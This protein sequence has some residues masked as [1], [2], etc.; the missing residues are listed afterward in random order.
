MLNKIFSIFIKN[1]D[2]VENPVVRYAYGKFLNITC[3]IFNVLLFAIK[4]LAGII[5]G[6]VAIIAD[7][8]NNITDAS[9]NVVGFLGFKLANLPADEEHPYGHGRYEYVASLVVAFI[10]MFIG[11]ELFRGSLDKILNPTNI[12]FE[13]VTVLILV[14][15]ILIKLFMSVLSGFAG[16]KIKSDTLI[17]VSTDSRNDVMST[18]AVLV[19]LI[20]FKIFNINIDGYVGIIVS[21]V[22]LISGIK[23][24]AETVGT[25]LGKAPDKEFVDKLRNKIMSYESVLGTHDLMVHDYGPGRRFASVHIEMPAEEDPIKS[26]EIIDTIEMDIY[27]EM[28]LHISIHY[29]PISTKDE[30]LNEMK[31]YIALG[32]K[33]IS[34]HATIHDLRIVRGIERNIAV[35]DLLLPYSVKISE[36]QIKEETAKLVK[37]KYSS[38]DINIKIDRDFASGK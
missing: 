26:H 38:F 19:S 23:I 8:I 16:K 11:I 14:V 33:K 21:I 30:L 22:I 15:S 35:F 17:A 6:S 36:K 32:V 18:F 27:K 34:E 25:L 3:I 24:I 20:I 10:I 28:N 5:S 4:L 37:D 29:D 13:I 12:N 7:A 9:T 1:S 2:D 31:E